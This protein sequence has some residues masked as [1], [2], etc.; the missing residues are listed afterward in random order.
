MDEMSARYLLPLRRELVVPLL[1]HARLQCKLRLCITVFMGS[2]AMAVEGFVAVES[3]Y[4]PQETLDRL[5]VD[6]Q[7]KGMTVFARIDHSAGAA[8]PGLTLQPT[9]RRIVRHARGGS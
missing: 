2:G 8:E 5:E 9:A 4:G 7:S 6:V 1:A 3:H